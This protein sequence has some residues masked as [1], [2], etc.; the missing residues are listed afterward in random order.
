MG[1]KLNI[2]KLEGLRKSKNVTQQELSDILEMDIST[3]GNLLRNG[4]F[5][6]KHLEKICDLFEIQTSYLFDEMENYQTA[7]GNNN[8]QLIISIKNETIEK[9]Q[10]ENELLRDQL[11]DK[12]Q[13][14]ILLKEK[15]NEKN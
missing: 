7:N 2:K 1:K 12:E 15:I 9:L 8:A 3:Y 6:V 5:R 10:T 4:D 14:I 13:I 11:K